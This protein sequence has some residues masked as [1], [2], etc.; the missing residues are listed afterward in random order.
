MGLFALCIVQVALLVMPAASGPQSVSP[1]APGGWIIQ[2]KSGGVVR[3]KEYRKVDD[4]V[5]IQHPVVGV[6]KVDSEVVRSAFRE[7]RLSQEFSGQRVLVFMRSNDSVSGDV[8]RDDGSTVTIK[9]ADLGLLSVRRADITSIAVTAEP[10]TVDAPRAPA[11]AYVPT[12]PP[13]RSS[14]TAGGVDP[15]INLQ[16][17]EFREAVIKFQAKFREHY[18]ARVKCEDLTRRH[19]DD[20]CAKQAAAD[21]KSMIPSLKEAHSEALTAVSQAWSAL[22]RAAKAAGLGEP[23]RPWSDDV[24][25][26][27]GKSIDGMKSLLDRLKEKHGYRE[28]GRHR[29]P[30]YMQ[31]AQEFIDLIPSGP[32]GTLDSAAT[33]V[34]SRIQLPCGLGYAN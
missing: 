1:A 29:D 32:G 2:L 26:S 20:D 33:M 19:L 25:R 23:A 31:K 34:P 9:H 7:Q 3:A 6:V 12:P 27:I 5:S 24:A 16:L 14:S 4:R 28:G 21:L 22:E 17:E 8:T 15:R 13:P 11:G 18:V 30:A 10:E